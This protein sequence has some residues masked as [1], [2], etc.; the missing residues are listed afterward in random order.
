MTDHRDQLNILAPARDKPKLDS[1]HREVERAAGMPLS[2]A[3][4]ARARRPACSLRACGST[5]TARRTAPAPAASADPLTGE[6]LENHLEIY[7]WSQYDDPSTYKKFMELPDEPRPGSRST[8]PT[9]RRTT[10]CSP[11]STPAGRRYDIIVPSQNAVAAADRGG[12]AAGDGHGA[13][14]EPEEPGPEVPEAV[15][16][17]DRQVPRHQGLR[18]HDVLLQQRRSSPSSRRRC[19]TSTACCPSTCSKGRTNL[20]DGAEEV[21][22]LGADGARAWTRTPT[23]RATST[24]V[25]E[26]PAVDPQGRHDDHARRTT[27][28]TRSP[29]RSSSARA[30]TATC[31]GSC[32]R[33]KKQGDITAV[34]P[35]EQSEMLGRQLVHPRRRAAPG[36]GARVD[37]LPARP[38]RGGRRDGVPQLPDP[39]PDGAG[40]AARG[41]EQRPALQ[42][43]DRATR[44]TTSTSSTV[45]PAGGAGSARR[46]TRS[47]RRRLM[48]R[49]EARRPPPSPRRRRR[50]GRSRRATRRG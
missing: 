42:R 8:R 14:A 21:V 25:Q 13:A 3:R 6:P 26:V 5:S 22:P 39:D 46:S 28:T 19:T 11:S 12:Q 4:R 35:T 15:V 29:G 18:H 27:S 38:R 31:A 9:T 32:R 36:R 44:T 43:P 2:P 20:L 17:P 23:A 1:L 45:S 50:R 40:A 7:N 34:L 48:A 33:R 37:Q 49:G 47:S 41:P 16:R 10:S 30:G 24:Q